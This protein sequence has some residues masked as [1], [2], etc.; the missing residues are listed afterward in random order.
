VGKL[1]ENRLERKPKAASSASAMPRR[2]AD[3]FSGHQ[4]FLVQHGQAVFGEDRL[5]QAGIGAYNWL[6][7]T[8]AFV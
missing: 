1:D 5:M 6:L 3:Q 7:P 8:P 4:S 2:S